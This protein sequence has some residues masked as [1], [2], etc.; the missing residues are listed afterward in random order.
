MPSPEQ[1]V[2]SEFLSPIAARFTLPE[3]YASQDIA[4]G[5][6]AEALARFPRPVL[7]GAA[8]RFAVEWRYREMPSIPECVE[9]CENVARDLRAAEGARITPQGRAPYANAR[10]RQYAEW[11]MNR[12]DFPHVRDAWHGGYFREMREYIATEAVR[13]VLNGWDQPKVEVPRE[14]IEEWRER[15]R[16]ADDRWRAKG[17]V[18]NAALRERLQSLGGTV[19]NTVSAKASLADGTILEIVQ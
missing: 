7:A 2:I 9:M 16:A 19:K 18:P 5:D 13:Q 17:G 3:R 6:Y 12:M 15:A 1:T 8:R 4:K 11:I 10:G 14:K